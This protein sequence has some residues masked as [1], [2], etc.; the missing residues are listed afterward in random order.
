MLS[1]NIHG[2]YPDL[3]PV[4]A[5]TRFAVV[6]LRNPECRAPKTST[7]RRRGG[8]NKR[9]SWFH[10]SS[11]ADLENTSVSCGCKNPHQQKNTRSLFPRWAAALFICCDLWLTP[12]INRASAQTHTHLNTLHISK[13]WLLSQSR[14]YE[15]LSRNLGQIRIF[16]NSALFNSRRQEEE[17]RQNACLCVCW[18]ICGCKKLIT[19]MLL[20]LS[21]TQKKRD[22]F[23]PLVWRVRLNVS[24]WLQIRNM[25]VKS[26][27]HKNASR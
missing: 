21:V 6:I 12:N 27:T 8:K 26:G 4:K 25:D 22:D 24:S 15:A 13:T 1:D 5:N 2:S 9:W 14:T 19:F 16:I 17:L 23:S 11:S 18:F 7:G 3:L 20:T 10:W